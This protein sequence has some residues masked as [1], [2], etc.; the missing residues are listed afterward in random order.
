[1][2]ALNI[3]RVKATGHSQSAGVITININGT[4][5]TVNLP[6]LSS[7]QLYMIYFVP[8]TGLVISTNLNSVGPAGAASWFLV[9]AFY[10]N[11]LGSVGFGSFVNITGVPTSLDFDY[12]PVFT[13]LGTVVSIAF[14]GQRIGQ[15]LHGHGVYTTGTVT[16]V[17]ARLG[18]PGSLV[19]AAGIGTLEVAHGTYARN[20]T[21]AAFQ[22]VILM[23]A[24]VTYT[25]FGIQSGAAA[26]L[27][28]ATG[29]GSHISAGGYGAA[30]IVPITGWT[31]TQL[32][33]L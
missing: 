6:G 20:S 5:Y 13:G 4:N 10:A 7:L 11:G 2:G 24:S 22:G 21:A 15:N 28:K 25:T 9:G 19:S 17:E 32:V 12:L 8:T 3:A 18:L 1:M 26:A 30:I 16:A 14:K 27:V 23:E 29:P 31:N 33:D